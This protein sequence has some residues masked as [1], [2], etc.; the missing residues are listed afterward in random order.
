M[1]TYLL[2]LF[3][4]TFALTLI[5]SNSLKAQ[6]GTKSYT[7]KVYTLEN[8]KVRGV[9]V[10][11]DDKGIY[12]LGKSGR[13]DSKPDFISA[14]QIRE[15]KLRRK[16]K[17]GTGTTIGLLT[18]LAIG[19]GAYAALHTDDKL[20]NTLHGV[21]AVLVM[22]TTSAIGGAVSSGYSEAIQINGRNE[23]YRNVLNRI[24][25]FIPKPKQ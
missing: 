10:A 15:I 25:S 5:C 21:G 8:K 18:G 9:L 24:Q 1:K 2:S 17:V 7:A 19:G 16:N 11:A 6:T 4:L 12:L 14:S 23:E 20:E 13:A 22:F 3:A